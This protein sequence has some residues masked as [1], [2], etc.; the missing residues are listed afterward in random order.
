MSIREILTLIGLLL[1]VIGGSVLLFQYRMDIIPSGNSP[2]SDTPSQSTLIVAGVALTLMVG[3]GAAWWK[4]RHL[5]SY[6]CAEVLFGAGLT[7]NILL[8]VVPPLTLAQGF[9]IG[10]S[11]YIVARGFNNIA[12]ALEE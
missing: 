2:A 11:I 9:A 5:S 10:S 6:G 12:D 7:L 4:R 3:A 1:I 8:R